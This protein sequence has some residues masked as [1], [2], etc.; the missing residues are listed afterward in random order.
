MRQFFTTLKNLA[1]P[2]KTAA[3]GGILFIG[4]FLLYGFT[5]DRIYPFDSL[6]YALAIRRPLFGGMLSAILSCNHFLWLPFLRWFFIGLKSAGF[7]GDPYAAIQWWNTGA[8][9]LLIVAVYGFLAKFIHRNWALSISCLAGFSHVIWLRSTGGEPYLTGTLLSVAACYL[10]IGFLSKPGRSLLLGM[11][12]LG[13][14][15]VN[16]HIANI[17]LLPTI[18]IVIAGRRGPQNR[19]N[20]VLA[21]SL[22]GVMLLP[23]ILF[24]DL[25]TLHGL[26]E[27]LVWGSGQVNGQLPGSSASGKFDFHFLKTIPIGFTTLFQSIVALPVNGSFRRIVIMIVLGAACAWCVTNRALQK[28]NWTIVLPPLAFFIATI[29]FF[30]IWQPGNLIYWASPF[31]FFV[32]SLALVFS[33]HLQSPP[34]LSVR[35]ASGIFLLSLGFLNFYRVIQPNLEGNDVKPLV[36]ICESIKKTTPPASV[37]MISGHYS[38]FLKVAIPY[39]AQRQTFALDLAIIQYY[40]TGQDPLLALQTRLNNCL[41]KGISV[42]M[43]DDV[44]LAKG[45]FGGWGVSAERIEAFLRSYHLTEVARLSQTEPGVLYRMER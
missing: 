34:G 33:P 30:Y 22:S 39:F 19:L 8:G 16:I 23:Y 17:I 21:L 6:L 38:G 37:I 27:W 29:V 14:M 32:L 15:A 10:L 45:E 42:Y 3:I 12:F 28:I 7:T 1:S 2:S 11:A 36:N 5:H 40:G 20:A 13:G 18:A 24:Y 31:V 43:M 4:F 44:L 41:E 9:A 25:A 26:K 35:L